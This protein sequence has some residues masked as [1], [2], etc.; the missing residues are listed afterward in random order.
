MTLI[1][2]L[3]TFQLT[4]GFPYCSKY[5]LKTFNRLYA[6]NNGE[7]FVKVGESN[8]APIA[9]GPKGL[10]VGGFN[11]NELDILDFALD[12]VHK[13]NDDNI[14]DDANVPVIVLADSDSNKTLKELLDNRFQR[15]HVL[16]I[17]E[18]LSVSH[19]FT[20]FSGMK[21]D[22]IKKLI[23]ILIQNDIS[24]PAVAIAVP[25]N[26]D[27]KLK[28]LTDEIINDFELNQKRQ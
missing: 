27:K 24:K 2:L 1:I 12:H 22:I 16:P 6:E 11:E 13:D 4:F 17:N 26:L 8:S 3:L 15:D 19:P 5:Q 10:I 20:L 21:M 25:N 14:Y 28:V 9:F 23:Y 18:A 7:K